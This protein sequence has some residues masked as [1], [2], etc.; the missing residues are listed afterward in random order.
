MESWFEQ[1]LEDPDPE[2][3]LQS[4]IQQRRSHKN[5]QLSG[6]KKNRG[7]NAS[8]SHMHHHHTLNTYEAIQIGQSH[9]HDK[10]DEERK[11]IRNYLDEDTLDDEYKR[12]M[13]AFFGKKEKKG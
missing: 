2:D 3:I 7:G 6:S 9:I 11:I 8:T 12:A 13:N 1:D 5:K 4:K 10:P